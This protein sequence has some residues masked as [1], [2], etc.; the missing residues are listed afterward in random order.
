MRKL[1][2]RG[3]KS[4]YGSDADH[5]YNTGSAVTPILVLTSVQDSDI[6]LLYAGL[7]LG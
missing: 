5:I 2:S 7:D 4:G 1:L 6:D 3:Y